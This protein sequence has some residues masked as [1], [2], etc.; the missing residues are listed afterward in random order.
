MEDKCK[1]CL[2]NTCVNQ[3]QGCPSCINAEHSESGCDNMKLLEC[4]DFSIN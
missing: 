3:C 1:D 2:C 4:D